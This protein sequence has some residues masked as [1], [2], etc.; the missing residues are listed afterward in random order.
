MLE[1]SEKSLEFGK[2]S[3]VGGDNERRIL[4]NKKLMTEKEEI[5][6]ILGTN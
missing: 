6:G 4:G 1:Y 3:S 5:L 2:N